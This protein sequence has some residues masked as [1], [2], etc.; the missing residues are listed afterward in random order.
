MQIFAMCMECQKE[1]GHPSFEPFFVPYFEDRIAHITCS[2]GHKSVHVIQSQKFEVLMDSGV[3]AL[4]AGFTL[5]ACSSFSAALERFYEFALKVL[6]T[7]HGMSEDTYNATYK[8]MARQ[9]ERQLG[10]FLSLF[11]LQF[12]SAYK[13]NKSIVEF[14]NSVI[15]KG[16]IPTLE[17]AHKFCSKVYSEILN[18][19]ERLQENL[20]ESINLVVQ[21]DLRE[22]YAKIDSIL[23]KATPAGG[24]F[25]SLCS[26]P[27]KR[28]FAEAFESF[29][30]SKEKL[31]KSI[32]D[33]EKLHLFLRAVEQHNKSFKPT[34]DGAA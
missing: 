6:A 3:N 34:S 4:D 30:D 14:R 8:E 2:R 27:K 12:G 11:A 23:P 26:S 9:S 5:E 33:M 16:H 28:T 17:E 15:H 10:A 31:L 13:P 22:R 21:S 25:F 32:P 18:I 24:M 1:L 7:H 19:T 29:Q 20:S